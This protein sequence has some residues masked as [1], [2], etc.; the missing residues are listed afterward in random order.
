MLK[1]KRI[2]SKGDTTHHS[3]HVDTPV[4][5]IKL[6]MTRN[7]YVDPNLIFKKLYL[8]C[9]FIFPSGPFTQLCSKLISGLQLQLN[10]LFKFHFFMFS[11]LFSKFIKLLRSIVIILSKSRFNILSILYLKC[12]AK[13]LISSVL[14]LKL[15]CL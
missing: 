1:T 10:L 3:K 4:S 9:S 12:I 8:L 11:C 13:N 7:I 2:H 5:K 14:Q 6:P 15:K